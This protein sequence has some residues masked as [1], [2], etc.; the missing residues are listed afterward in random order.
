MALHKY[1][2]F[3]S[4]KAMYMVA[5]KHMTV[6][7]KIARIMQVNELHQINFKSL[8]STLVKIDRLNSYWL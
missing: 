7:L 3:A 2:Y 1:T 4:S 5:F 8:P 6:Q